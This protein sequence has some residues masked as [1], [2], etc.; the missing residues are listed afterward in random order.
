MTTSDA[1]VQQTGPFVSR[2]SVVVLT[3]NEASN[4]AECVRSILSDDPSND[5]VVVDSASW[6]GTVDLARALACEAPGRVNV[7]AS[8]I[9]VPIGVARN[10]GLREAR[11][12]VVAFVSADATVAP[13][14]SKAMLAALED[15]DVVY[16]RQEH[17]PP[18]V[19]VASVVRGLRYHHFEDDALR[20]AATYASNVNAAIRRVVFERLRYVT[21]GPASA[22][23]DVLF[24]HEAVRSGFRIAY[25]RDALVR[26]KDVGTLAGELVK[27]RREG[28]GWG[29]LSPTLGLHRAV[30]FWGALLS[31][32]VVAFAWVPGWTTGA[33]SLAIL[34]AP[35]LRRV[36]A[37]GRRYLRRPTA[38]A[39]A[40][41]ASP[42]FDLAFLGSY[43]RGL[44]SRRRDLT[45]VTGA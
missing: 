27:N 42:A 2:M 13:G 37:S 21:D 32:A 15:A 25:A 44:F 14:W 28:Y 20:P 39:G 1:S 29:I 30:A 9:D 12:P 16:G 4:V 18:S 5:V 7:L 38:L 36:A 10:I 6:D 35:A 17:A 43:V 33:V 34:Y 11:A 3:R 31:M 22:L 19:T 23:D 26:H 45:G 8:P 40:L 41:L 24:T